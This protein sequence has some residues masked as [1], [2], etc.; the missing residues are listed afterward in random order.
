VAVPRDA[1][2]ANSERNRRYEVGMREEDSPAKRGTTEQK[3]A[4]KK[5][6]NYITKGERKGREDGKMY[7]LAL[8]GC[9][10]NRMTG[11]RTIIMDKSE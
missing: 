9:A 3:N 2:S 7:R 4:Q 5:A 8:R 6:P 1:V 11:E 10:Q